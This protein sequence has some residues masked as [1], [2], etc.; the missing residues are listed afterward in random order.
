M[1]C[2]AIVCSC[3]RAESTPSSAT[4]WAMP[5]GVGQP[6]SAWTANRSVWSVAFGPCQP[7]PVA[8]NPTGRS[9]R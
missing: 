4:L 9:L 3:R 5:S 6:C 8:I 1:T 7:S 2:S